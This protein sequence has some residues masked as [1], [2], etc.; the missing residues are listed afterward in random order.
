[1][2]ARDRV[3]WYGLAMSSLVNVVRKITQRT[4]R[5]INADTLQIIVDGRTVDEMTP[6]AMLEV[7]QAMMLQARR[8]LEMRPKNAEKLAVD[9]GL[10]LRAGLPFGLTSNPQILADARKEAECNRDLRKALPGGIK[11]QVQFG[12]PGVSTTDSSKG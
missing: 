10:L 4:V 12:R 11:G 3:V 7:A 8:A 2:L 6:E 5:I 1:M 9:S